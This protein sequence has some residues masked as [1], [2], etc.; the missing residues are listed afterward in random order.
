MNR[1]L[2]LALLLLLSASQLRADPPR[3]DAE[4]VPLPDGVLTRIGSSKFRHAGMIEHLVYS[5]DGTRIFGRGR[6][7]GVVCWDAS[8]GKTL[9]NTPVEEANYRGSLLHRHPDQKHVVTL[10]KSGVVWL[11]AANGKIARNAPV[12]KLSYTRIALMSPDGGVLAMQGESVLQLLD[13]RTGKLKHL[14]DHESTHPDA[15]WFSPDGK[16]LLARS[17]D[18]KI[19]RVDVENGRFV[20]SFPLDSKRATQASF[21]PDGKQMFLVTT[22][23]DE[24]N[25]QAAIWDLETVK[26]RVR[27][28]DPFDAN[29]IM[30]AKFSPDSKSLYLG[31]H[32]D[33]VVELDAATGKV[34]NQYAGAAGAICIAFAPDGGRVA[35]GG[36]R[37]EV[38]QFDRRTGAKLEASATPSGGVLVKQML[39]N[40]RMRS[41]GDGFH[42]WDLLMGRELKRYPMYDGYLRYL[43]QMSPDGAWMAGFSTE[44]RNQIRLMEAS[45]GKVVRNLALDSKYSFRMQF[46]PDS[47][48]LVALGNDPPVVH[49]WEAQTGKRIWTAKPKIEYL[50]R[51]AISGDGRWL[52]TISGRRSDPGVMLWNLGTGELVHHFLDN[53]TD[54]FAV[55][56]SHDGSLLAANH[57]TLRGDFGTVFV[58]STATKSQVAAYKTSR[59]VHSIQFSPDNRML[60]TYGHRDPLTLH[61]LASNQVR[62]R[63]GANH[64][65]GFSFAFTPDS[66]LIA[67]S[68]EEAPCYVWDV[69]DKHLGKRDAWSDADRD[70]L[71]KSL[72]DPDAAKAFAAMRRLVPNRDTA[73]ELIAARLAPAKKPDIARAAPLLAQLESDGFAERQRAYAELEKMGDAIESFLRQSA[74]TARSLESKQRI[75]RLLAKLETPGPARLRE[76]RAVETLE[77]IGAPAARTLLD[78]LADGDPD[79]R[80]TREAVAA[81]ARL[82]RAAAP[83]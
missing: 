47:R 52:A 27:L 4:G 18:K 51:L 57:A 70:S 10:S 31:G 45:T 62:H 61:E 3:V 68:S 73:V 28:V 11:D 25:Y 34:R 67:A 30:L 75:G 15:L 83:R 76:I 81:C 16:T 78:K 20:Q 35:I 80:L 13:A 23:E 44:Q 42:E 17:G 43:H 9:W 40:Q 26:E 49:V 66:S 19:V 14:I 12:P 58:F 39:S 55:D 60:A 71:W 48:R 50:D 77:R 54:L 21:S 41:I 69:Y 46:T 79:A 7:R 74:A 72:A 22:D 64:G 53:T 33:F 65:E 36:N 8:T 37:S 1:P 6:D 59:Y 24:K 5:H 56:L 29:R 2:L 82:A 38:H 63:L 32:A